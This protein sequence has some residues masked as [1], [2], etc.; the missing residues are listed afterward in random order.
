MNTKKIE[1][2]GFRAFKLHIETLF[3][4]DRV[5]FKDFRNKGKIENQYGCDLILT[6]DGKKYFIELK[7][8]LSK[9]LPTNIRF[10]H[11]T[12]AKMYNKNILQEM[13]VVYVYN[14]EGPG[15][16]EFK[17]F[18]FGE[19]HSDEIYVEPHFIIQPKQ[20]NKKAEANGKESPIKNSIEE[21]MTSTSKR[22]NI[23]DVFNKKVSD[24]M[25]LNKNV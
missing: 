8:S 9:G 22:H 2:S 15:K 19:F 21:V 24:C 3:G 4:S 1:E 5:E 14:L 17:F 10:T 12:L 13:I 6:L 20:I 11:Q 16:P 23:G 18:R 7:A 25:Q